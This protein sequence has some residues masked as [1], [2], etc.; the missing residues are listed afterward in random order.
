MDIEEAA[1]RIL[2]NRPDDETEDF[3]EGVLWAVALLRKIGREE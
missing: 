2:D 1:T 3:T